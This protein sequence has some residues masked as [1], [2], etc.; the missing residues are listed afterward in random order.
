MG[1]S[2][3]PE[4]EGCAAP[5]ALHGSQALVPVRVSCV[6]NITLHAG[7]HN[8]LYLM[9]PLWVLLQCV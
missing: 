6:I 3:V 4:A 2:Q 8:H 5:H 7:G 9:Q 1:L